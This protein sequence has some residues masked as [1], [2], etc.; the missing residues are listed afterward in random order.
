MSYPVVLD[1]ETQ[2][3]FQE[4]GFD[5][6]KLKVSVVGVYDYGKDEYKIYRENELGKL[7]TML[8]HTPLII[9]FNINKF[10]LPVLSPY[11]VGDVLQ[12]RTLDIL[13]EVE[14]FLG[15]RVALDDLAR[16]TL[17]IKK[18]GH[19]FLA[20]DYFLNGDWEK[21]EKYCLSDVK[22]TKELYEFGK[23]EGK[24]YF[25]TAKGKKE[26]KVSFNNN[27]TSKSA[28]SLSLPF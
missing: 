6:R 5:H 12:F 22:V 21:L 24:L 1:L 13:E 19:G 3:S 8:E 17:G 25:Q 10:D 26:I 20:I 27:S 16:A 2:H 7:F 14:K 11:Y 15:F 9:G 28:V 18:S 23:K 4:V